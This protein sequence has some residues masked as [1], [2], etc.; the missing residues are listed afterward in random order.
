MYSYIT[1]EYLQ[2]RQHRCKQLSVLNMINCVLFKKSFHQ[3]ISEEQPFSFQVQLQ[4]FGQS[5]AL[6]K[7]LFAKAS[8]GKPWQKQPPSWNA[9]ICKLRTS[10]QTCIVMLQN[11]SLGAYACEFICHLRPAIRNKCLEAS[12]CWS[13]L[14]ISS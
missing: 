5:F 13:S 9:K 11:M 14:S 2:A 10:F 3:S 7:N 12:S 4:S 6:N 8:N 1:R